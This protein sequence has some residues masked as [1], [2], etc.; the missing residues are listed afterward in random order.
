MSEQAHHRIVAHYENCLQ[1][2]GDSHLG[3][4]WPRIEDVE[5]RHQVMLGLV[6]PELHS[7]D[8][9]ARLLDF[10]CGLAHFYEFLLRHK[11]GHVDYSGLDLSPQ[12]V[13][14]CREKF[15]DKT[16]YCLD[17]LD[18][19]TTMPRF[20]Y[21]VLNGVF[22]EKR[23]LTHDEM[24]R[25]FRALVQVVFEHADIGIAFNVMSKQVDWERA[26]LFHLPMDELARFVTTALK[27]HFVVR[28]DYGLYEYTTYVYREPTSWP[29]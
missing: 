9:P 11:I 15:P 2:H 12:F 16:F 4:D 17:L 29:K 6:R 21:I 14:R 20:D 19:A 5:K 18:A 24:L 10:G 23:D 13:A 3:V 27:R 7:A 1:R 28:H 8:R 26:D 22:T 25:Y